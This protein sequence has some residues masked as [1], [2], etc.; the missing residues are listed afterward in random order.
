[1]VRWAPAPNRR[2]T[3][4]TASPRLHSAPVAPAGQGSSTGAGSSIVR[5]GVRVG[6]AVMR[7][8]TWVL[9]AIGPSPAPL[10]L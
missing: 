1:M 4:S 7:S 3:S 9:S 6:S 5:I 2:V 10:R 8:R